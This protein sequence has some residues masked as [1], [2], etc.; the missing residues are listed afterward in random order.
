V[1]P[2]VIHG[3]GDLDDA[4]LAAEAFR[5]RRWLEAEAVAAMKAPV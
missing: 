4:S 1:P 5:Y 2:F 3:A